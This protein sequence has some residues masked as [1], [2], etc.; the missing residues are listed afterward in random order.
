MAKQ[1]TAVFVALFGCTQMASAQMP[2]GQT[3]PGQTPWQAPQPKAAPQGPQAPD[4][5]FAPP[6]YNGGKG[7]E[8]CPPNS[9][10][11]GSAL[12][13]PFAEPHEPL[14]AFTD[15]DHGEPRPYCFWSI[16]AMALSRQGLGNGVI[17]V[18]DPNNKDTGII[19]SGAPAE[20]DFSDVHPSY[21]WGPRASI[22]YGYGPHAFELMGY[23]LFRSTSTQ[24]FSDRGRLD[25]PF[26]NFPPPFGFLGNNF[27]WLQ[28]DRVTTTTSDQ[29]GNAEFNYRYT[30]YHGCDFILGIRYFDL[31]ER[32]SIRTDDE[33]LSGPVDP[34]RIA[35]YNV[36]THSRIIGPQIGFEGSTPL[37]PIASLGVFAKGMVGANF[38][39]AD[40]SLVRG[41]GFAGPSGSRSSTTISYLAEIGTFL[42]FCFTESFHLRFGYQGLWVGHVPEAHG[43]INFNPNIGGGSADNRGSI[44]FHGPSI[45]ARFSF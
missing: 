5:A 17:A 33:G 22:G 32:F 9:L 10:P 27:L 38:L 39:D 13:T 2:P 21:N 36:N 7:P 40:Q 14:N 19:P 1:W 24:T 31:Q 6:G 16:G 18:R 44:F 28:A 43:Q 25:L 11:A 35:D 34:L 12:L 42:D 20:V 26:A 30:Y 37:V 41:D 3:P 45:E 8:F 4:G 29:I 15:E 23:Y